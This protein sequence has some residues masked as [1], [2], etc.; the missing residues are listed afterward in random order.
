MHAA[1]S[2]KATVGFTAGSTLAN[3]KIKADG[4]DQSG[5]SKAGFTAGVIVNLPAGKNFMI[6]PGIHWVGKGTKDEEDGHK[7]LPSQPIASRYP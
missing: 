1:N 2:Q 4:E 6:Q 5:N 3:Y 7:R